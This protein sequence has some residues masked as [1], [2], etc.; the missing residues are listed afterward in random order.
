MVWKIKAENTHAIGRLIQKE[1]PDMDLATHNQH[2]LPNLGSHFSKGEEQMSAGEKSEAYVLKFSLWKV[3]CNPTHQLSSL[4]WSWRF[5]ERELQPFLLFFQLCQSECSYLSRWKYRK[6][7]VS[8]E[9]TILPLSWG[10]FP[11]PLSLWR[12]WRATKLFLRE[13][14]EMIKTID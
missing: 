14:S 6:L 3:W 8:S 10:G 9:A 12:S 2:P 1:K 7:I 13:G 5:K 4:C 11:I